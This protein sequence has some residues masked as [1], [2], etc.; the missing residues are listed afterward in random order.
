MNYPGRYAS[1]LSDTQSVHFDFGLADHGHAGTFRIP[2]AHLLF[3]GDYQRSGSDLIISDQLHHVVVPNYFHGEKRPSLVS[4]EGAAL[5]A[6][7]IDALTGHVAYAQAGGAA[8]AAKVVGH[9]VKMSGSASIVRNGVA[10]VINTGDTLYQNDVVQTGSNSTLGL[11]LDDGTAFNLSANARF[12]LNDFNFDANG[13]SNSSLMTLVQGAA[14]FVAGQIAPTGDMKVATPVSVIGIRGTAVI[15]DI[16][17]TDGTVS[18]SVVDQHDNQVHA[19]QVYNTLGVLIATVASNGPGLIL[20]PTAAL[21]VIAQESNK[22]TDQITQE[23]NAFQQVLNTYDTGKQ[24]FPNLPQHTENNT[25][26]NNTNTGTTR[27]AAMGSTPVLSSD[28][29]ATTVLASDNKGEGGGEP[30]SEVTATPIGS[31]ALVVSAALPPVQSSSTTL[32][33]TPLAPVEITGTGGPTNQSSQTII[34]TVDAAFVGTIIT[35][36]DTYNGVTTVLGNATVTAGGVWSANVTLSGNGSHT[37]VAEDAAADSTS[38]PVVFTLEAVPPAVAISTAGT[39]TT[40]ATQTLSGTVTAAAGEAAIGS[41]VTLFDT[42]NGVTT[43]IGTAKVGSD[44]TWSTSVTLSGNG[45]NSIVAQDTD[46]AGNTGSSAPVTFTLAT[47]TPTIAI[48]TPIAGDNIINKAEAAAG[49]AISGTAIA[50]SGGAAVDGQTATI[51]IVDGSNAVKDTYTAAVTNGTWSVNVT[52]GQAQGLADGNYSILANLSDAAGNAA[53]P[54]SQAILVD[55]T[56]PTVAITTPIAGDNI[57]N[58]SEAAAGVTIS[59]TAAAGAAVNGQ[60]ATIIIADGSNVIKDI[61]ITPVTNGTWSVNVT[62]TQVQALADGSYSITADITDTAGNA[63]PTASQTIA[64]ET[65]ASTVTI[66]TSGATTNQAAQTISGSVIAGDAAVGSTVTLFDTVNGVTAQVGTA[67]VG[68]GG[69]WSTSVTLSGNGTHS[70]VAQDTDAAGNTGSSAPVTFTLATAAPTIAITTPIAGDNII[71]KSEAAAGVTISGT[72]TAGS[73]SAA[74]NGQTATITILDGSNAVKDTLT[75]TVTNGTWSVNVTAAQAQALADGSYS[76]KA[77]VSDAAGNAATNASQAITVDETAPTIAITTPIAGDNIINKAEAA[78]GV[79]IS[80][81]ATAGSGGAAVN[82]QTATITILD[83]SNAVKDT[84]TSTVTNGTWSVNVTAAQAEALADGSYSIKANVSDAAGNAAPTAT[85]AVAL[86]TLA[87]TVTISTAGTTTSQVTQT[88]SGTVTAAVGEAAVGS[89]AT[90]FDTVN[91]VTTQVGTA[92]VGSGGAWSTGV[93]LSGNGTNSIVAQDTDAAGNIASSTPVVFTLATAAPTIAITTPIAGDNIINK[94]EAAAGVTIS[95]TATA[96]SGGAAANGQTATITILDSS[97]SIKDTY[98]ATVTNGTWSVNVT[99]TQAQALADGSYGIKANVSDAAGNAA[100]TATQAITVAET[101]PTIAITTP[102]AGDNIINKSEAAVGV[103]ISGTASAGSGGAAVNGQTATITIVDGSNAIKDTYTATLTNGTWSVNVTAAQA[104]ALA[105]GSYSIK[106]NVSDAAGN[107]ATTATQAIALETL[108]PTV[109]ISTAGTTT[110]HE[111][112]T[113]SGTVTAA[114]GEAAVGSTVTLFD[115]VNGVTTQVGTATVGSGGA[116]STSVTLSGNGTNS[117]V[118]QDTDAAGNTGSSAPVTFTLATAAPTIAITTPVAGDNIINKSEAAAGVTISG[119]A[120]A[121]SAAVNGQTATITI[122]DS[123]N[124][125]KDTLT[126]TVTNGAWSVNATAAQAQAL[127]DGSYSIKANVSDAAGNAATTATQAITVDETA[128]TIAITTPIAGDNVINKSEAAA[129]VTISGTATAGSAAVNGQTATITILDSSNAIKDTLTSTVTNGTWSV[130]VT[131]AQAQALA[132]GSYSIKANVSDA[133]G[134]AA[135][136]ATQAI[137]VDETAPTIAITTPIAG[138]NIINKT[139]AAASVTISGTAT[140]G[141]GGAAVNGQTATITVLDGSNAVKDTYTT[142]VTNGTWSVNVTAAQAQALADGSYSIK[143]NV[144]DAAGNAASIATQAIAVETIAPTV[145]IST[146]GTTTTQA[147]QAIS[148]TVTAAAGEAAIGSTVTLF[149]TLNGVTTQVGTATVG[150]GGAWSTGV[151]LSG[152]GTN[153]IVA[154]DTDVAGNIGSSTPVTFTLTII[155]GG[156]GNPNGGSWTSSGNWSSGSI[157]TTTTNVVFSPI[158]AATPYTVTVL[159]GDVATA[160]SITL[161]D[162]FLILVDEGTLT[163]AGS[164]VTESGFLEI[165]N[166]GTLSLG[167]GSFSVVGF[168]GTGGN[169]VLGSGFT[170][171]IDAIS[172]ATGP[173]TLSGSG[174]DTT[175]IGDAIDVQ[176]VGGTLASPATLAITLSGAITGAATGID[177]VQLGDGDILVATSGPVIGLA[178]RGI[179]AEESSTGVGNILVDGTGDVTGTRNNGNASGIVAE[180]LNPANSGSVAVLQTG[181]I[182]G[183]T[184]GIHAF[185]DG[186]GNVVVTTAAGKTISGATRYGIEA[187]SFGTGS[188]SVTTAANDTIKS[189]SVGLN[190]YN[191]ATSVQQT[192]GTTVSTIT[193]AASGA[194]NSGALPT[195]SGSR[196][197]GILAGYAGG[198]TATPNANVFGNVTISNFANINSVGGDG[199]RGYNY[200][201]GNVTISDQSNT[202]IT[203]SEFGIDGS[204]YGVGNVSVSTVA[205]DVINSG[206]AGLQ[207]INLATSI[208]GTALSTVSVTAN[209]T[210]NSGTALTPGGAQPQGISAGY[211]PGNI[212]ATNDNVNGTVSVDNSANITAAAGWGINAYNFGDGSITITDEAGT[213]VSGAQYGIQAYSQGSVSGNLTITIKSSSTKTTVSAGSLYGLAA[214]NAFERDPGNILI[215]TSDTTSSTDIININSGGSGIQASN[216]TNPTTGTASSQI[217][218]TTSTGTTINSGFDINTGG[219]QPGGIWAGYAP[220]GTVQTINTHVAGNVIV[221]NSATINA[222]SGVGI[223]LYNAGVGNITATLEASS[224]INAVT[225]GLNVFAQ[226]GGSV[227]IVNKGTITAPSGTGIIAGTGNGLATTG[228]GILSINNSGTISSLGVASNSVIQINN[229]SAQDATLTNSGT[230]TST[231]FSSGMSV[232]IGAFSGNSIT[233]NNGRV[234]VNNSGTISGDVALGTSAFNSSPNVAFKILAATFNNN[235]G[236]IWRVNG[237]NSFGGIADTINNLGSIDITGASS[238]FAATGGTLAFN[239]SNQVTIEANSAAVIGGTVSGSGSFLIG[240]H[241]ELEFAGS[242]ASGQ[243]VSFTGG[244]SLLTLD[245][246]SNFNGTIAGFSLRDAIALQN[247]ALSSASVNGATTF[248]INA[249]ETLTAPVGSVFS[250]LYSSPSGSEIVLVPGSGTTLNGASSAPVV[251]TPSTAQ[252]YQLVG[253]PISGSGVNGVTINATDS[254]PADYITVEIDQASP[255]TISGTV[256]NGVSVTT[257]GANISLLNAASISASGSGTAGIFANA[258]NGTATVAGSATLVDYGSVTGGQ[259]GIK[260]VTSGASVTS[261]TGPLD[262]VV[263]GTATITGTTTSTTS[264]GIVAISGLGSSSVTTLAGVTVNAGANGI[265]VENQAT[266][267]PQVNGVSTSISVSTAGTI[268]SGQGNPTTGGEP[269]GILAAYL[270]GT[271]PPS[272][273]P[274]PPLTGILGDIYVNN[275]ANINATSGIG[276]AAFNYGTGT[277][278]VSDGSGTT[279]TAKA[280]GVTASGFTQYGILAF[281]YGTGSTAVST[282]FGSKIDSGGTGINAGNQATVIAAAAAS[283]VTVV[284]LGTITSG[285]NPNNAGGAPSGIQAG[286]NPGNLGVFNANVAGNVLVNDAGN[287]TAAA[288]SGIRAYNDGVGNVAVNLGGGATIQAPTAANTTSGKAAYGIDAYN[289]GPGSVAVTTSSGDVITS[290]SSGI[291]AVNEA[292]VI[293]VAG[294]LVTVSTATGS[295]ITTGNVATNSGNAPSGI[296]AGFLGGTAST[297]NTTVSGTVIVNNGANILATAAAGS[298]GINAYNFGTGDVTV[299]DAAGTTVSGATYGIYAHAESASGYVNGVVSASGNTIPGAGNIAINVYAGASPF[300]QTTV[301][302]TS[303]ANGSYG[304][305]AFSTDV[306]NISVITGANVTIDSTS[307]SSGIEAVNEASAISS[308]SSIV[309]TSSSTI[310]SGSAVTGGGTGSPPGGIVAGYLGGASIPTMYPLN[311][312]SGNVVVNNFGNITAA[313]GDG[314][315]AFNFGVGD[316][317]VNDGAGTI[318]AQ[319]GMNTTAGY[320]AGINASNEGTG[321]IDVTTA[322]GTMID[323]H[324]A[325]S[326]ITAVNKAFVPLPLAG[327]V[328]VPST[329]EISVSAHGTILSGTLQPLSGDPAAGILAGYNPD[330]SDL[331]NPNVK[332][333]VWIDDYATITAATGTDGIRGINYGIGAVTIIAEAGAAISA[334]RYGIGAFAYD[335]GN[336]SVTNYANVTATTAAIDA[337]SAGSVF[338][339]NYGAITGD[340]ISSGN[341]TFLNESGGIWDLAGGSTFTGTSQLINDGIIDTTGVSSIT[342]TGLLSIVND[343]MVE[344]QSGTFDIG[345]AVAGLGFFTIDSGGLLEFAAPVSTGATVSFQGTAATLKLDDVAHFQGVVGGFS[346]SDTID[347]VGINPAN[348]S[349]STPGVVSYGTGSIALGDNYAPSGFTVTSDTHGGT[350]VSWTHQAPIISTSG[351][352]VVQNSNGTTTVSGLQ[353]SDSDAAAPTET[354]AITATTEDASS[355]TSVSPSNG[356][357]L[358]SAINTELAAGITYNPGATPPATD[359][360]TLS[361]VDAFGA[362]DAVNFVFASARVAAVW[363]SL[364]STR[365]PAPT[366][367]RISPRLTTTST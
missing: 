367:L 317:T 21:N 313:S 169:L 206:S 342:T 183:G 159:P 186:N 107:A 187:A 53:A 292:T 238:F 149:D 168:A 298:I 259:V 353:I 286:F 356:S 131:A 255:I 110:N 166:G 18:V 73:G 257:T 295:S 324:L 55:E 188:I 297:S 366:P 327:T 67:T 240:D 305:L 113:I 167:G 309:V 247:V 12:M 170:G 8:P 87:P 112:Q 224:S 244:N 354:F 208:P 205:G 148:G 92:T 214:L 24:Q 68:S 211:L 46:A 130:N 287:I 157:P 177:A 330:A 2:D 109:T 299:N 290:G 96:G 361:V 150:S 80:G 104:Q 307:G 281:N 47:T 225:A 175:T 176:A 71:N 56:A 172:T 220:G 153:S 325:G 303:N 39:T 7:V 253:N 145:A 163:I 364:F 258:A 22:T 212:Q 40:Q 45:T 158:G 294:A 194:I 79:T 273:I 4:P 108:A 6:S 320:G 128:P 202:T 304:I 335:G 276:I 363:I 119:I 89:T 331:A 267:V 321:N 277:V 213:T 69:A 272:S 125:I 265:V 70:I 30:V 14:S 263:G 64:V 11:V 75:S 233:G 306:G 262:I 198:T 83:G 161:N 203:A 90:L 246:P 296:S 245:S 301:K 16:S 52:A 293:A 57:I 152:N 76:I 88:I 31:G 243:T 190:V 359:M 154:Q 85:Q 106:A 61:Y 358:L 143:A 182:V 142:S 81:T 270:G 239:N 105:D 275:N 74:V 266:S 236:G 360:L 235:S 193:V 334:G 249:S 121:G 160:N 165:E 199:I 15:L 223:G 59:G 111:T 127:A 181:N 184:D 144:S 283:T 28:P 218:I 91:G 72:A 264:N 289:L 1:D 217:S 333:S 349:V 308:P 204:S 62:A 314:I 178:G 192:G 237:S 280:A 355:G 362:T 340:V 221:D 232:A 162:P 118:A 77:N 100:T 323:S 319:G 210:I 54:A 250:V 156:W 229:F 251:F 58:R 139:E 179:L 311:N 33:V 141:S 230:I 147:T 209:G 180:N 29:P 115:T 42:V 322:A 20:T 44:G 256:G 318:I 191:Q 241:A 227:T 86:E 3:S 339:D 140:A 185:T 189:A 48:T 288:G 302:E 82:G 347:L 315:R 344:V 195:G 226:G 343:G 278:S 99:A 132:D 126:S 134:N 234:I 271:S 116:W 101:A 97:N 23:F 196:P 136:T 27:T 65:L 329:S 300:S 207:A 326:G 155:A 120:T 114:V 41:T 133:A 103:T 102:I 215:K 269:A 146:A 171:T 138:D 201:G 93:T 341:A 17:S 124:A 316:V 200:G 268:N 34:G 66:S 60:T 174:A 123:S 365:R 10:I 26:Q 357:G 25:N 51:T 345:A 348:V 84:L 38:T 222:A 219:N 50:A 117:I 122:L 228:N 35:I 242:V 197:A 291:N 260:A 350:D 279:I 13:T 5:D 252:F 338:I 63:A 261:D 328:V 337:Q 346:F 284:A 332:G 164:L 173:V 137:T 336:V 9:V 43:Q 78:A 19:I 254:N 98:T 312:L 351:L 248:A 49:V 231:L 95:G 282:G 129:G 274:N 94:T 310:N 216:Q 135:A 352:S 151:T 37:I 32:V 285:A 36:L